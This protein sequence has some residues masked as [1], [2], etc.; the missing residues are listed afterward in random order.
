M[1]SLR[2]RYW[3]SLFSELADYVLQTLRVAPSRPE[4]EDGLVSDGQDPAA[5]GSDGA[6]V[7]GTGADSSESGGG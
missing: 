5:G 1:T 3:S 7:D 6:A 2:M 4:V